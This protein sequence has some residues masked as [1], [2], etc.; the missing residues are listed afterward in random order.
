MKGKT[1]R[2]AVNV[3]VFLLLCG[4]VWATFGRAIHGQFFFDDEPAIQKND[5]IRQLW[6]LSVPLLPPHEHPFSARPL[7]N[8]SAAINYHFGELDPAGYRLV[9]MALHA[10]SAMLLFGIVARTLQLEQFAWLRQAGGARWPSTALAF[11]VALLWAVHPLQT[12]SVC[13]VTQRTELMFG[14]FY[15]ATLYCS[16]RLL[17]LRDAAGAN[18]V[19]RA[20]RGRLRGRHGFER[21]H[22]L[23]SGGRAPV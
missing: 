5:T 6:P 16:L 13:Y 12:E 7:V 19:A 10:L 21:G 11:A 22:G 1:Q 2:A 9:N 8:L 4:A 15:L 23:G 20:G 17:A 18:G 14:L 3:S